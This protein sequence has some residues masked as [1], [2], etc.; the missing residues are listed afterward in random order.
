MAS[1]LYTI[2]WKDKV[3]R[4]II[5]CSAFVTLLALLE[6][7]FA[8]WPT[9]R[10]PS[11]LLNYIK[12]AGHK[13]TVK[14]VLGTIFA[15]LIYFFM[16]TTLAIYHEKKMGTPAGWTEVIIATIFALTFGS[17]VSLWVGLITFILCIL[18]T[19]YLLSITPES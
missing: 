8:S 16:L 9:E 17:I 2:F 15:A 11:W 1:K 7:Y 14:N 12:I 18:L 3:S 19:I 10:L 4:T 6:I 13:I 5:L